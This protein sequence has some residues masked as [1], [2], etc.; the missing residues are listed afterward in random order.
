LN[1][2]IRSNLSPLKTYSSITLGS[3]EN[4]PKALLNIGIDG[5]N[6]KSRNLLGKNQKFDT[7]SSSSFFSLSSVIN[8][9][10]SKNLMNESS[11]SQFHVLSNEI[12][13]EDGDLLLAVGPLSKYSETNINNNSTVSTH[14]HAFSVYKDRTYI[15]SAEIDDVNINH[16]S[17]NQIILGNI[18]FDGKVYFIF[19]V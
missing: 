7:A 12:E 8:W 19:M 4:S 15:K 10:E 9:K 18:T 2:S 13:S 3:S 5:N 14:H 11:S 6:E 1:F 16:F 17:F